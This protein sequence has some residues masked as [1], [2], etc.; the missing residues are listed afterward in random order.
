MPRMADE[1]IAPAERVLE[2]LEE[3]RGQM[4]PDVPSGLLA[5]VA[6][7]EERYQFD[8]DRSEPRRAIRDLVERYARTLA[9]QETQ[10]K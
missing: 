3:N 7:I 6:A 2:I 9:L 4:H 5:E 10:A 1:P 8:D